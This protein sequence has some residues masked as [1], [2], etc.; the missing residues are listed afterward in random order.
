MTLSSCP[1]PLLP[2]WAIAG[3]V[4]VGVGFGGVG[5][6]GGKGCV[7]AVYTCFY[8][9]VVLFHWVSQLELTQ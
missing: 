1:L 2:E 5:G 4:V 9:Q 3:R 7:H 8:Y 6:G